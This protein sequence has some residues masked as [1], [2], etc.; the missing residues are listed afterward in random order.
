[1]PR[2]LPSVSA[3]RTL[4]ATR[5]ANSLA[6]KQGGRITR[7][8]LLRCGLLRG[9]I[10]RWLRGGRL[11]RISDGVY[12]LGPA[13]QTEASALQEALL[14]AGAGAALS[15][16]TGA[17]WRGLLRFAGALIH[18]SAP[19]RR[20][21]S[22][23][24]VIHH[25]K[26][27]EREWHRGLPVV[28]VA[29]LLLHVGPMVSFPGLRRAVAIADHEG[30]ISFGEMFELGAS[31]RAGSWLLRRALAIHMPQLA[32]T[33]S[34]LEDR[35]LFLCEAHDIDLPTPNFEIAG[36]EVDAV[37]PLLG[38]AVELDGRE[39]HGTP[40]AVVV[41]RRRELAIRNA[42]FEIIRYGSEQI[43]HQQ[44]ATALDLRAAIAR[45]GGS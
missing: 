14:Q 31:G 24:I 41:D 11:T 10:G 29:E 5:R 32:R 39:E 8:Q 40:A 3:E 30:L 44:A 13:V 12:A 38:V 27:L 20:R 21:S 7:A 19:G 45:N 15:H 23:G 28:P 16:V 17:W 33:R 25:P 1:M 18:V 4:L 26:A 36:Y 42:G 9:Q 2:P 22:N 35:F 6:A 37:W 34:P 43:D